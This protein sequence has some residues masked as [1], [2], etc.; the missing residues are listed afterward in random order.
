MRGCERCKCKSVT[1]RLDLDWNAEV[2]GDDDDGDA[3]DKH[4][5]TN[6]AIRTASLTSQDEGKRAVVR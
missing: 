3:D 2:Y 4:N 1:S 5:T 6:S